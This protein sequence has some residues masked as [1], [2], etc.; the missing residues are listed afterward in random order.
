MKPKDEDNSRGT[1]K[2]ER[3]LQRQTCILI[4]RHASFAQQPFVSVVLQGR[5]IV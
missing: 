3:I 2:D 5:S 1:Q 4:A